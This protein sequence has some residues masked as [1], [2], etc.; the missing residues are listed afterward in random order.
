MSVTVFP[1]RNVLDPPAP[2]VKEINDQTLYGRSLPTP[3]NDGSYIE[4]P[5]DY[6]DPLKKYGVDGT[7]SWSVAITDINANADH[8]TG[9]FWL[10]TADSAIWV[11]PY[12]IDTTPDTYYLAKVALSDGTVT[13]VGTCQ[14][15]DGLF[16]AQFSTFYAERASMGSG[17][18]TIRDGDQKI[19][20]STTD[21]SI[22]TA[23]SQVTQNGR[24]ISAAVGYETADATI[25]V[26]T[27]ASSGNN[28]VIMKLQRGGH[29]RQV[30]LPATAPGGV[31]NCYPI[32]WND[33]VAIA[34]MG[35]NQVYNARFFNRDEFDDWLKRIADYYGFPT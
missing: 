10:D 33:Y 28:F 21:G 23:A 5:L 11:W 15:G 22:V 18:L 6:N 26:A 16:G 19:V 12:D 29:Y 32:L 27:I 3:D 25:Y 31:T 20:L 13:N 9:V 17:D 2:L 14:P 7:L 34:N 8:W 24:A 1:Q 30:S 35:T 4:L